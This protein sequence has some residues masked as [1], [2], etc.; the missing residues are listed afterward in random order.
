MAA[1]TQLR[2]YSL[3]VADPYLVDPASVL[4]PSGS[5]VVDSPTVGSG[6]GRYY[7]RRH[8]ISKKSGGDEAETE[9]EPSNV[10]KRSTEMTDEEQAYLGELISQLQSRRVRECMPR[11]AL[12][13]AEAA[14]NGY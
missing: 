13:R 10:S 4:R 2:N 14:G 11:S 7:K 6:G 5:F 8:Y 9:S 12:G 1:I 3:P